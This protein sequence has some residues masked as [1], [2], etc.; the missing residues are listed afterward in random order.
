MR[1]FKFVMFFIIYVE[2]FESN[3]GALSSLMCSGYT[4]YGLTLNRP[5]RI[6]HAEY[7]G[8]A[9]NVFS[10]DVCKLLT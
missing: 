7:F 1:D 2:C 10:V 6:E 5:K 4:N 9:G 3:P 8:V